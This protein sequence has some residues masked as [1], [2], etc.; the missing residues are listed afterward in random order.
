MNVNVKLFALARQLVGQEDVQLNVPA[1]A[2]VR[3]LKA[4]L[5]EAHP[6]LAAI[7]ESLVFAIEAEYANDE[8]PI[9]E[10]AEVACIP[11]VSGGC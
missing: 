3:E 1:P 6:P 5:C 2:P 4:V 8:T 9:P 7:V 11:P 10:G